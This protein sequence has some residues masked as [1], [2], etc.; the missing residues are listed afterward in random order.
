MYP[1]EVGHIWK[2]YY[3]DF[4]RE[5]DTHLIQRMKELYEYGQKTYIL[6][7]SIGFKEKALAIRCP[8]ST[9][10]HIRYDD[11][12]GK[13]IITEIEIYND[14]LKMFYNE[15]IKDI[16]TSKKYIGKELILEEERY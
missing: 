4:T 9:V 10:G 15:S 14:T 11:S 13:K 7:D 6:I 5:C 1:E 8:G 2:E 3:N 12:S 16:V